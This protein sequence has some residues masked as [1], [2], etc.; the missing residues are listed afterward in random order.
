M[1]K[2]PFQVISIYPFTYLPNLSLIVDYPAYVH[3]D[4]EIRTIPPVYHLRIT[5]EYRWQAQGPFLRTW[6]NFNPSVDKKLHT[7]HSVGCIYFSI[8]KLNGAT[9][10]VWEWRNNFVPHF[11]GFY[12]LLIHAVINVTPC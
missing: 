3:N 9:V 7:L 10:D 2:T 11:I 5:W 12:W 8:T 1:R 6:F 4:Y